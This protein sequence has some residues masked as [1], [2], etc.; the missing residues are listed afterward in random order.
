MTKNGQ[1]RTEDVATCQQGNQMRMEDVANKA[2]KRMM[3]AI[4]AIQ[5]T[6]DDNMENENVAVVPSIK[7]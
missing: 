1:M 2:I 3:S 7:K 5:E 6:E 4:H